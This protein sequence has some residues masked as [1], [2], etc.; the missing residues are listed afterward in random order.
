LLPFVFLAPSAVAA[1][2]PPADSV[3]AIKADTGRPARDS[4]RR[5]KR[6]KLVLTPALDADAFDTPATRALLLSARTARMRQDSSLV[7]YDATAYSR[8]TVGIGVRSVGR[9]RIAMRSEQSARVRWQQ[10]VGAYVDLTGRRSAVPMAAGTDADVDAD[11]PSLPYYPGRDALWLGGAVAQ[12]DVDPDE[13]IH[14]LATGAEAYYRYQRGDSLT[15]DIG[16]GRRIVLRELRV[17]ARE[18]EWR[19]IVGSFWFDAASGQLVRAAYRFSTEMNIRALAEEEDSTAFQDVPLWVK[20]MIFPMRATLDGVAVDY[21]LFNG[22]WMPRTQSLNATAQVS[23]MRVPVT[24][25]ERYKYA[26]VNVRDASLVPIPEPPDGR[27]SGDVSVGVNIGGN[28]SADDTEEEL[29][30]P[31]VKALDGLSEDTLRARLARV[32]SPD[33]LRRLVR[34][35]RA[36]KDTAEVRRLRPLYADASRDSTAIE[37]KLQCMTTGFRTRQQQMYDGRV[38]V[39]SRTPCDAKVLAQS[40]DLPPSLFS[41]GDVLFG[42]AERE[43]LLAE[44]SFGLQAGMAPRRP[45]MEFELADGAL[46]YNRVEGLSAGVGVSQELGQG[47]RWRGDARLG[48]GDRQPLAAASVTRTN[49]RRSVTARLYRETAVAT[50][51]GQPLAFGASLASLL[52]AHDDGVYY[53]AAGADVTWRTEPNGAT[54]ARAFVEQHTN[55]PVTTRWSL[56]GGAGSVRFGPNVL[57]QRGVWAGGELRDR[58]SLGLDPDDWR[59]FTDARLEAA[60]GATEYARLFAEGTLTRTLV[61]KLGAAVTVAGGTTAGDAPAQRQFHLGG[62]QTVR[63]QFVAPGVPGFSGTA[64]WFARNELAWGRSAARLS[65]FYDV[66]WA[67]DRARF[68][69]R[70]NPLLRGAGVGA[71]FLDGLIRVDVARGLAPVARTRVDIM[72]DVRF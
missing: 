6:P 1:Q 30:K 55:A 43:A 54:A 19:R 26:S 12:A 68:T 33:S 8:V 10:G 27:R 24:F 13:I 70:A 21:G 57:A 52:Y 45:K 64:F 44:L 39:V 34:A 15:L 16:N 65:A 40:P 59:L 32:P 9:E 36:A 60:T 50:D 5:Q 17:A 11:V 41:S 25:E 2:V 48:I 23:L 53:R 69:D 62:L 28:S 3:R 67:G 61:G 58:R 71:T 35:A 63:G 14:P 46:R 51:A 18:P 22:V 49:G 47:W 7:A 72:M 37:I 38:P 20:P 56:S 31:A 4:T 66:G 29:A 42:V